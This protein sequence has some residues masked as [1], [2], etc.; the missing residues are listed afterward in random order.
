MKKQ[1]SG[2]LLQDFQAIL[3]NIKGFKYYW[4]YTIA[5]PAGASDLHKEMKAVLSEMQLKNETS[6]LLRHGKSYRSIYKY[7][8]KRLS[9]YLLSIKSTLE[10]F[11]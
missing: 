7:L 11:P 1:G 3:G 9:D 4:A 6:V 2:A 8:L 10:S 5:L